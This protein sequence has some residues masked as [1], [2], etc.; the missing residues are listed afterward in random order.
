MGNSQYCARTLHLPI[1]RRVLAGWHGQSLCRHFAAGRHRP[2]TG[3]GTP[4]CLDVFS[5]SGPIPKEM[6]MKAR[7]KSKAPFLANIDQPIC[8]LVECGGCYAFGH[9]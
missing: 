8:A 3:K 6:N 7:A 4:L 1:V 9:Q 5:R 2:T